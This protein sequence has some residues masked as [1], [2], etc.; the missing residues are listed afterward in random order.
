MP[1][2]LIMERSGHLTESGLSSYERS[3]PLQTAALSRAL[4]D[5][6]N[7]SIPKEDS[8]VVE[9]SYVS[10][11]GKIS[12]PVVKENKTGAADIPEEKRDPSDPMKNPSI[13]QHARVHVQHILQS[14]TLHTTCF[15]L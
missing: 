3:N 7:S 2:K 15:S 1:A 4:T 14:L 13:P 6:T 11:E 10:R 12:V 9:T 5:I 8:I